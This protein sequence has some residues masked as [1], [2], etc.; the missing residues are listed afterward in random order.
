MSQVHATEAVL[1][2]PPSFVMQFFNTDFDMCLVTDTIKSE[3]LS[4]YLPTIF[5]CL[6]HE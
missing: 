6:L 5:R 3:T 4:K 2:Q 1:A